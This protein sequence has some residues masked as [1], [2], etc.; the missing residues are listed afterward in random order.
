MHFQRMPFSL[1]NNKTFLRY[2][3]DTSF[4]FW[5]YI[6]KYNYAR[7]KKPSKSALQLK[8]KNNIL[9]IS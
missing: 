8:N 2:L 4:A 5:I 6:L 3:R 7:G 9:M 1:K